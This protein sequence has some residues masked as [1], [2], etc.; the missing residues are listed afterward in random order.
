MQICK[1]F[2]HIF[3]FLGYKLDSFGVAFAV[4]AACQLLG[5]GDVHLVVSEDHFWVSFGPESTES[6]EVTWHGKYSLIFKRIVLTTQYVNVICIALFQ[7]VEL[8][9]SE[10]VQLLQRSRS[11]VGCT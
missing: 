5:C 11:V 6:A 10:D 9:T 8:K 1:H 3:L 4:V 7:G 2:L